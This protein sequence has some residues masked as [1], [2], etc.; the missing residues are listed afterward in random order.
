MFLS[1]SLAYCIYTSCA[2]I[3]GIFGCKTRQLPGH[4]LTALVAGKIRDCHYIELSAG[5]QLSSVPIETG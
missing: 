1:Y 4:M 5:I 3:V 2:D